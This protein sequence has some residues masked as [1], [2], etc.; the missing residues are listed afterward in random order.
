[1]GGE[2]SIGRGGQRV[3][4]SRW[5]VLPFS[6]R[7]WMRRKWN[8]WNFKLAGQFHIFLILR[9]LMTLIVVTAMLLNVARVLQMKMGLS[10]LLVLVLILMSIRVLSIITI[11][12]PVVQN[13]NGR[14][15][16]L[17]HLG[18]MNI[19]VVAHVRTRESKCITSANDRR[20]VLWESSAIIRE[21]G[22]CMPVVTTALRTQ[23]TAL[24]NGRN[25]IRAL[26]RA[27]DPLH[28]Q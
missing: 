15:G 10:W 4:E 13:W 20:G 7:V 11:C 9:L 26:V 6:M 5:R 21:W 27:I 2:G 22:A 16:H 1:M 14:L 19:C 8:G 17:G 18:L 23:F 3:I 25:L 28:S 24:A 12:T